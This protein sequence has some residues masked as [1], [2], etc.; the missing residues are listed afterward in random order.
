[1]T[2]EGNRLMADINRHGGWNALP[3]PTLTEVFDTPAGAPRY[4]HVH[5]WMKRMFPRMGR[6]EWCG[7][8]KRQTS[9]ANARSDG[10]TY[11]RADWLELCYRCH[12]HFDGRTCRG[13][14]NGR[15]KLTEAS[16]REIRRLRAEGQTIVSLGQQFG[17][18]HVMISRIARGKA[19]TEVA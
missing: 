5:K 1:M 19:W 7:S 14:T 18:S 4:Q 11:N 8:T 17:V 16:V 9:Y 10:Y 15:S 2:T 13:A 3:I 6:C 12:C